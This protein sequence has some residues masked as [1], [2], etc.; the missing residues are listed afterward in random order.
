[1]KSILKKRGV[2]SLYNKSIGVFIASK[3]EDGMTLKQ[4]HAQ[5]P[6][7]PTPKTI[8]EWKKQFPEF[9]SLMK[10]AY[11]TQIY[12]QMDEMKELSEELLK[13]DEELRK[14]MNDAT[15]SGDTAAMKEA[16]LFAKI[17]ATTLRDRRDN[18]RVRL[19]TIK[20][21]LA[22]LAHIFLKEFKESPKA[23]VEINIPSVQ[24]ISYKD[25][26]KEIDTDSSNIIENKKDD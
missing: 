8:I 17:H 1:M 12:N 10:E 18:I 24:V 4:I 26:E 13:I 9:N 25:L 7:I 15:A 19:D 5:Y 16:L 2:K 11:G 20:F 22:K 6:D 3:V 21:S 14:K 23:N